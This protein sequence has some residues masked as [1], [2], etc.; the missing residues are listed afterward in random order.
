MHN[1]R[2]E[3]DVIETI[4]K[5]KDELRPTFDAIAKL[6]KLQIV[7]NR[8]E[9]IQ[10]HAYEKKH[11]VRRSALR[12]IISPRSLSNPKDYID[13][14]E[15]WYKPNRK[16]YEGDALILYILAED[17]DEIRQAGQ[18]ISMDEYEHPQLI[19]A[20]PKDPIK[21]TETLLGLAAAEEV[22]NPNKY[23]NKDAG[24]NEEI[25]TIIADLQSEIIEIT[26]YFLQANKLVWHSNG[27]ITSNLAG[28]KEEE[29][30][31]GIL[32]NCFSKTPVVK[33]DTI[34]NIYSGK[35]PSRKDR[36]EVLTQLL[37]H[38][39]AISVKKT[40][41]TA[42]DRIFRTCLVD[43]EIF[44]RKAD[45]G[46]YADY[47]VRSKLPKNA[48]LDEIWKFL[49]DKL[50]QQEH[51]VELSVIVN[52]LLRPPYGLSHQ[53]L[54]ILL[55]SFFRNY[56]DEFVIFD[57]YIDSKKRQDS[58]LLRKISL[59]AQAITSIVQAPDD[60]VAIYYEVRPTERE[61]V[62]RVISLI[63]A[64]DVKSGEMGIWD[65]GRDVLLQW[66]TSLPPITTHAS[67]YSADS[68]VNYFL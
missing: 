56:L 32:E 54:E 44:E 67:A 6:A 47:D 10:A 61:Y 15:S 36:H 5:E 8:I 31:S 57:S 34:A 43:T 58:R 68:S 2:G 46:N 52:S 27:D 30:I 26:D 51:R 19:F 16:R 25:E 55:A 11:F 66:F 13:E 48:V 17:N 4:N 59:D 53:L 45:K 14:I 64:K 24:D 1:R 60:Y 35:D 23:P 9:P 18:Y 7:Q 12:R 49:A 65:R 29:Y 21:L 62:N 37:E 3:F 28:G 39:G 41:G 20:I 63:T 38:R 40:G 42:V 50:F 33:D 22:K